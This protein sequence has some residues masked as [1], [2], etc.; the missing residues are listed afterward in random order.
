MTDPFKEL[1]EHDSTPSIPPTNV[2]KIR[3]KYPPDEH[4]LPTHSIH[5]GFMWLCLIGGI[6]IAIYSIVVFLIKEV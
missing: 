3:E 1:R 2:Q 5:A 6:V 4:L